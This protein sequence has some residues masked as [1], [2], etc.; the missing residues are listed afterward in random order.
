MIGTPLVGETDSAAPALRWA[1]DWPQRGHCH[2]GERRTQL[3]PAPID[4]TD[5]L[6]Q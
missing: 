5:P 6:I 1:P 3:W 4:P 2:H